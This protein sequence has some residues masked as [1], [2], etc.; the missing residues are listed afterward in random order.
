M[1][2]ATT[3]DSI[4]IVVYCR[5]RYALAPVWIAAAIPCMRSSPAGSDRIER[6]DTMP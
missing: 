2:T 3:S 4:A 5:F 1:I 6:T